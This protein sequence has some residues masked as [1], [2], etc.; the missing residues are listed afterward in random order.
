MANTTD[1]TQEELKKIQE[2]MALIAG[3]INDPA[4]AETVRQMLTDLSA[5][6]NK[7]TSAHTTPQ[8]MLDKLKSRKF[9]MALLGAIAGVCGM[10]NSGGNTMAILIFV[11]LEVLSIFGYFFTEGTIDNTR[12]KELIQMATQIA[13]IVGTLTPTVMD[14]SSI[15]VEAVPSDDNG[16]GTMETV[17][18][19]QEMETTGEP[20]TGLE[21]PE[22]PEE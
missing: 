15:E 3:T 11:V 14:S 20:M 13:T 16:E 17:G 7:I 1:M 21:I 8:T 22:V 19:I 18:Y 4:T 12:T 6:T 10:L 5:L 2:D 9:L